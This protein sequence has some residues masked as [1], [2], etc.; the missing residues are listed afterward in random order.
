M[1][2]DSTLERLAEEAVARYDKA[3]ELADQARRDWDAIGRPLLVEGLN[4]IQY[5][6]PALKVLR[7]AEKDAADRG[8]DI[9]RPAGAPGRKPVAVPSISA[10]PAAKKRAKL[11]AV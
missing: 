2:D 7:A 10:S 6:H 8:K 4:G 9:P 5:E 1:T 11:R 3:V